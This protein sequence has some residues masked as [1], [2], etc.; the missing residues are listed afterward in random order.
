[1]SH[2]DKVMTPPAGFTVIGKTETV[3]VA[4]MADE[5]RKIYCLQ[6]HPEVVHT[7]QG[8]TIISNFCSTLQG[9]NPPGP[10]LPLLMLLFLSCVSE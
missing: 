3:D 10:C 6:F 2:G 9:S 8:E 4:A 7:E 5:A 1:M